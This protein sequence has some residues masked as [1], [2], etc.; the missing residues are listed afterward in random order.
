MN[1]PPTQGKPHTFT[2]SLFARNT[3]ELLTSPTIA[4]SDF[5]I[6]TDGSA[7][8]QLDSTPTVTPAGS[9]IVKIDLTADEVGS[10]YFTLLIRDALGNEWKDIV[11]HETV[12]SGSSGGLSSAPLTIS[13]QETEHRIELS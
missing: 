9:G 2:V 3:G 13:I 10:D 5:R 6:S 12:G 11:Y 4:R 8:S 1:S 7:L